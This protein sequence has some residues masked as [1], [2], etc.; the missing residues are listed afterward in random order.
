[1]AHDQPPEDI[2]GHWPE[3]PQPLAAAVSACLAADP[4]K[5]PATMQRFLDMIAKLPE[6]G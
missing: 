2:S 1:M 4:E 3:I 6:S 5:R